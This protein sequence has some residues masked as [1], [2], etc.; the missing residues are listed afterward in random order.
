[1]TRIAKLTILYDEECALCVSVAHAL[2][3]EPAFVPLSLRPMRAAVFRGDL[4]ELAPLVEQGRF[5][6]VADTGEIYLDTK[7]RLMILWALKRYRGFCYTLA[8]PSLF[9][10]VDLAF[11]CISRNRHFVSRFLERYFPRRMSTIRPEVGEPACIGGA[12]ETHHE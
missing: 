3:N 5:I 4:A 11:E 1:M 9:W 10:A 8:S 2:R 7:A 6:V 12:C